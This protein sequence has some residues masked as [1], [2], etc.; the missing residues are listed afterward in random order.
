MN[1]DVTCAPNANGDLEPQSFMLGDRCIKV[2]QI[3]DRWLSTD[4]GYFKFDGSDGHRYILRHD[5]LHET[6]ELTLFQ[7]AAE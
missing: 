3:I 6:W 5:S 7:A 1:L 2:M 4:H